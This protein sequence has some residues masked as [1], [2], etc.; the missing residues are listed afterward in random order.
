MLLPWKPAQLESRNR[1]YKV[2]TGGFEVD[3]YFGD[4]LSDFIL[5]FVQNNYYDLHI[6]TENFLWVNRYLECL[7]GKKSW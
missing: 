2:N 4:R 3:A 7:W 1:V 5:T 6:V